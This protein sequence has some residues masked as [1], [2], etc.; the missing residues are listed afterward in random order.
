MGWGGR[1]G[2]EGESEVK[3]L[4]A[5]TRLTLWD[6]WTVAR[7]ALLSMGIFQARIL[8]WVPFLFPGDFPG[9]NLDLLHF[10]GRFQSQLSHQRR[11]Q[12]GGDM[13]L[14]VADSRCSAVGTNTIL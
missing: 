8:E 5:H 13:C 12:K 11:P 9:L 4:V 7:Q 3:V 2:Q 14:P 1:E 6:P 10:A